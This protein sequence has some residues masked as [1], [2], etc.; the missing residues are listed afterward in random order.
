MDEKTDTR[1]DGLSQVSWDDLAAFLAIAR[2]GGLSGA[3]RE[4]GS[5]PPTLGRRM[6]EMER[7]LGRELFVRRSHGY[8]LTDAG[9][10]L[11]DDLLPAEM[12]MIRAT[13]PAQDGRLPL[14]RIT[15]GT[16]TMLALADVLQSITGNP[17]DLRVRLLQ[18]EEV[19]S[20]PRREAA[21]GFRNSRPD[22]AGLATRRLR[23]VDFA[24]YAAAGAPKQWIVVRA[25][26]PSARW[27][28]EC[29]GD[30]VIAEV[31][32]PRLALDLALRGIGQVLLPTF[33]GNAYPEL[34]RV[35]KKVKELSH[36][37]W[38]VTHDDDRA[39]PEI[40]RALDRIAEAFG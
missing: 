33:I 32:A 9:A 16:W 26:T 1:G 20:I 22:E 18:G 30:D 10:R 14:V 6:R 35:G 25:Q 15:A 34:E 36:D 19:L 4:I 7:R 29:C 24:P 17:P 40:R 23:P 8:D 27:V 21:I 38:L 3:A 11:R 5:S 28:A 2:N 31:N 12:A 39:L 13:I 37:Q